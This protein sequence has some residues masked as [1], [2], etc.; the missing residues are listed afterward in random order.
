MDGTVWKL[1]RLCPFLRVSLLLR[2]AA[3]D[4]PGDNC[5]NSSQDG[6]EEIGQFDIIHCHLP[7]CPKRCLQSSYTRQHSEGN[8]FP[9]EFFSH[10]KRTDNGRG[11]N[12]LADIKKV[13]GNVL[14]ASLCHAVFK[15]Q[16]SCHAFSSHRRGGGRVSGT[17]P[18]LRKE[19]WHRICFDSDRCIAFSS[20]PSFFSPPA[21][22]SNRSK[23][24][25]TGLRHH[26]HRYKKSQKV[27]PREGRTN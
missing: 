2:R 1:E 12:E 25:S 21:D 20:S 17:A 18:T 10:N 7:S 19:D 4:E 26:P 23:T 22:R 13:F 9:T 11:D 8:Y 6:K 3:G 27:E 24:H 16:D 15:E 14:P 5:S